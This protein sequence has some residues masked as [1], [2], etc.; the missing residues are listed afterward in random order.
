MTRAYGPP[1]LEHPAPTVTIGH[2]LARGG[3]RD[4][5][6]PAAILDQRRR[7]NARAYLAGQLEEV[8]A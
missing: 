8:D 5:P 6:Q 3:E 4:V 2:P 1:R 7:I